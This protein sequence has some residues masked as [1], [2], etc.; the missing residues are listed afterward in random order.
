MYFSL[1]SILILLRRLLFEGIFQ[2]NDPL[3]IVIRQVRYFCF[4][5][6]LNKFL[7]KYL[8]YHTYYINYQINKYTSSNVMLK[9]MLYICLKTHKY[10]FYYI[11]YYLYI[12]LYYYY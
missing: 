1:K 7:I 11:I 3:V 8:L 9:K 2:R 6:D 4:S 10:I 5:F 12:I